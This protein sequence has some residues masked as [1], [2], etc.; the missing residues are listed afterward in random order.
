M[1]LALKNSL[2]AKQA[3]AKSAA[4]KLAL[5][6]VAS[7]AALPAFA[8]VD[9]TPI[10][11]AFTSADIVTGIIAVASVVA[12]VYTAWRGAKIVLGMIRG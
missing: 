3:S 10:S 4:L 6:T 9:L 8:A 5:V 12:V 2:I 11:T 7:A 1:K